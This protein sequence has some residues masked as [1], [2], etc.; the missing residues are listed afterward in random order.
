[1]ADEWQP[2]KVDL[3]TVNDRFF[4]FSSG[5]G[6]DASV[7]ERV[8]AHPYRKARF[9]EYYFTWTAVSTFWRGYLVNPPQLEVQLGDETVT[10]VTAIVQN[11]TPYTFFN[12]R[13]I[14]IAEN[15]ELQDGALGGAVLQRA[16]LVDMPTVIWRAFSHRARLAR[17][18]Q[19]HPYSGLHAV[20]VR[21]VDGRHVPI[22][23]DGDH[24]GEVAEARYGIAP[25]ALTVV[26]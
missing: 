15:V 14:E 17:H 26:A 8:D 19:V 5:V 18:R 16:N 4:T 25:G 12:R 3:G 2:R 9:G 6:L 22:Q 24:V 10:G 21:S 23:V 11:A 20:R 1:M 13:P 7:V